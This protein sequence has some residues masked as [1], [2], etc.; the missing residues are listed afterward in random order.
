M[1]CYAIIWLHEWLF[2]HCD[3]LRQAPVCKTNCSGQREWW[4]L[5]LLQLA[6]LKMVSGT[7]QLQ[8]IPVIS[9]VLLL[10]V[11]GLV[12]SE[13]YM[14]SITPSPSDPCTTE[15]CLTLSQFA[16]NSSNYLANDTTM[17]FAPG[18][19][20]LDSEPIIEN[21]HSLSMFSEPGSSQTHPVIVC[22]L[23]A[24]FEMIN[25]TVVTVSGFDF[26][27]CVGNRVESVDQFQLIDSSFHGQTKVN[28]SCKDR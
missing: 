3:F 19:H 1:D 14:Y 6:C 13:E 22:S 11:F 16:A 27:G 23:H 15:H 7:S 4:W 21:A 26:A 20:S 24:R 28:G 9:S 18:N 12:T 5:L 17:I 2:K 25:V 8:W 10:M